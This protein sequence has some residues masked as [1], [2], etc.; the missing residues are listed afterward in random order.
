MCIVCQLKSEV[1][2]NQV[3]EWF[4]PTEINKGLP[5]LY[6]RLDLTHFR[7]LTINDTTASYSMNI[8]SEF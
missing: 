1:N 6:T 2:V 4:F 3:F 7:S 8:I 5:R